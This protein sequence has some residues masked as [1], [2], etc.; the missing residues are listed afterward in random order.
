M[1]NEVLEIT[2]QEARHLHRVMVQQGLSNLEQAAEWIIKW[3]LRQAAI[4]MT[5]VN[6]ALYT[7]PK[8]PNQPTG[9]NR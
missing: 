8:S 5:G 7:L 4:E 6:R 1:P 2:E 3:R 9:G